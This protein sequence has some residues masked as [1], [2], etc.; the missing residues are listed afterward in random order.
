MQSNLLG[1]RVRFQN[2]LG[3]VQGR[4]TVRALFRKRG[5]DDNISLL[6]ETESERKLE[7]WE[8]GTGGE[9][10]VERKS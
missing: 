10:I 1:E 7:V 2:S 4:G 3:A 6:I 5:D 9:I 8:L